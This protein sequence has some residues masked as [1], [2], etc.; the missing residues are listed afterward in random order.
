MT[1]GTPPGRVLL[2]AYRLPENPSRYRVSIWRRLRQAGALAVHR[3]LFTLEDT[4]LNRLRALD[5]AH[6]V[7]N[8]GGEA[9]MFIG[10]SLNTAGKEAS[11]GSSQPRRPSRR[12]RGVV[13]ERRR[14]GNGAKNS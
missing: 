11:A 5:L 13:G 10:E 6:D 7:E 9:W 2:L 3:A 14:R 8:W 12:D 1:R 4:P